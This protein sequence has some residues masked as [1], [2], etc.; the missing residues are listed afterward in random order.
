MSDHVRAPGFGQQMRDLAEQGDFD[1]RQFA[2]GRIGAAWTAHEPVQ[3]GP[4]P[5]TEK[6]PIRQ[7]RA[8]APL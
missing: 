2:G 4:A 5:A 8:T 6:F 1:F 3:E 7:A